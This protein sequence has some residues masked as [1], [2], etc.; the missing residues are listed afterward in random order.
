[1]VQPSRSE[2]ILLSS[3]KAHLK[4]GG[5]HQMPKYGMQ[6]LSALPDNSKPAP[7]SI[8][9]FLVPLLSAGSSEAAPVWMVAPV[10]QHPPP[11]SQHW[12][13]HRRMGRCHQHPPHHA[14]I[15]HQIILFLSN[16][17]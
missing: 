17:R 16:I 8:L 12:Q 11:N 2:G 4:Q 1:M 9:Q 6:A 13:L 5:K 14:D 10:S 3:C 15:S 7:P